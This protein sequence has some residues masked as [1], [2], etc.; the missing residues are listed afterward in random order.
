ME[1]NIEAT[2]DKYLEWSEV[3]GASD[4]TMDNKWYEVSRF[5]CDT[6]LKRVSQIDEEKIHQWINKSGEPTTVGTRRFKLSCIKM[7]LNY[8]LAKG[9]IKGN[10]A[11]LVKV[12][13]RA[14]KHAKRE[15]QRKQAFDKAERQYLLKNIE[16]P[17]W[18][19]A[20]TIGVETGL[21]LGDIAQLE[22]DCL[23]SN[24]ITVWTD[25]KDKRV[26]LKMSRA[27]KEAIMSIPMEDATY[28]F[29]FERQEFIRGNRARFSMAFNR[30]MKKHGIEGKSFHCTRVTFATNAK[31]AGG[32]L[33]K[34]AKDLGHSSEKTTERHYIAS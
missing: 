2:L 18:R 16:A 9:Y 1:Y 29:P 28:L 19:A 24:T 14:V 7:F 5:A 12:D 13:L 34:I 11:L 3:T 21:R 23:T 8:C 25:K 17:F 22:W 26:S 33:A 27:L 10:P 20:F 31:K 30:L 15:A 6:G 32:S 4:R